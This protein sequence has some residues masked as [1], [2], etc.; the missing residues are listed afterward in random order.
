LAYMTKSRA[1]PTSRHSS[2]LRVSKIQILRLAKQEQFIRNRQNQ[3]TPQIRESNWVRGWEILCISYPR[4]IELPLA[5]DGR[6]PIGRLQ[7]VCNC[8]PQ[9][10][11]SIDEP[12]LKGKVFWRKETRSESK[13]RLI[14]KG[15]KEAWMSAARNKLKLQTN[16]ISDTSL[17]SNPS[18]VLRMYWPLT[19]WKNYSDHHPRSG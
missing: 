14:R 5:L 16:W 15:F 1:Y 9:K 10:K 12:I 17:R 11:R 6:A 18:P 19:G 4:R 3:S 13:K 2:K 8:L 7:N